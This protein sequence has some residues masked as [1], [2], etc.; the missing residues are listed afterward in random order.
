MTSSQ[1]RIAIIGG[2]PGGLTLGALLHRRG[3]P[4]MIYELRSRPTEQELAEP[5]G[6][7][8]L[9][10]ESGLAAIHACGLYEEFISLTGDCEESMVV[11]DKHGNIMHAD[12]GEG[13]SRPEIARHNIIKLFL[14]VLP[15]ESIRYGMKLISVKQ[16]PG[17]EEV[18]L[19]LESTLGNTTTISETYDLV[20]GADGAWSRVRPILSSDKPQSS[21]LHY[22]TMNI[23]HISTR[24]PHLAS[25]VGKGSFMALGNRHGVDS[26]RA[27]QDS[28]QLYMFLNAPD[29]DE[30]VESLSKLSIP[31]LKDHILN[32]EGSFADYSSSL[33]ELMGVAFDEEAKNGREIQIKPLATLPIGH[34]W[35]PTPGVTLIGDAG[36]LMHPAGEGVN[37][38][39]W[40]ALDLSGVISRA[41]GES[42]KDGSMSFTT[43]LSAPMKEFEEA[44]FARAKEKA[45]EAK[46]I[47][48]IMF[49]E[50]GAQG[51]ADLM[52]SFF[53]MA[54][55]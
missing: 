10:E 14:S 20:I 49:S 9:H 1:P 3:V 24:Y 39:M 44:M 38:A 4:F 36:H 2:G 35:D 54:Q 6:M 34:R 48:E 28:A 23:K 11:A 12:R 18:T 30:A 29:Q 42:M 26:H 17:T 40:D 37:L 13:A 33:K 41:W 21:S 22:L 43:A 27:A 31:E 47:Y 19:V 53:E 32:D 16:D 51:L 55:P 46:M 7:L 15:K 50:D 8:D 5:S 45:E 25:L 52:K